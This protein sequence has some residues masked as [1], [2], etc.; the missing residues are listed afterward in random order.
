MSALGPAEQDKPVAIVCGGGSIPFAVADAVMRQ[1]RPM[2]LYALKGFADPQAVAR[3]PHV[4]GHLGRFGHFLRVARERGCRDIVFI[5]SVVRPAIREIRLD[6]TTLR[7]LPRIV[8]QFRGG[9]DH[10]LSGIS[11]IIEDHGFRLVGA[12]EVAPDILVPEGALSARRPNA[13]DE[14]DMARGLAVLAALG[15]FDVGQAAVVA[16]NHILAVEGVGGTDNML[17]NIAE[18][19]KAGRIRAP[20][21]QGVLVKAPKPGQD[22]RFDLPTIGPQTVEAVARAGLGG[23]AVVAGATIVAEPQLLIAAADR[24][25]IFIVGLRSG[26]AP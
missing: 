20:A 17:A 11:R 19:R 21:G 4:W 18:L 3:Y 5:G 9:D 2:F 6:W 16:G 24:A 1:G 23:I 14:A 7:L 22:R 15:P 12:H 25:D 8:R 26:G 13:Q 10:L